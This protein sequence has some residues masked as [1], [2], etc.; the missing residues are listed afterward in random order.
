[1][2][3]NI[4][5]KPKTAKIV[6][7][8]TWGLLCLYAVTLFY[9]YYNQTQ[10]FKTNMFESDLPFHLKFAVEDKYFYSFTTFLY[11]ALSKLP[12]FDWTVALFLTLATIGSVLL[13]EKLIKKICQKNG[14]ILSDAYVKAIA[15]IANVVIAF[16]IPWAG[17]SHYVAYQSGNLWHN[18][19][20]IF[21]RFFA[22]ITLLIFTKYLELYKKGTDLKL[23]FSLSISL[24][25]TT[26]I[27]ASFFTV[28]GPVMAL[29]LLFDLIKGVK[30][31]RVFAAALTVIP[32]C[33]V[34]LYQNLVLFGS[35]TGNGFA[36][37]PFY[38]LSLRG[39]HPKVTFILSIL[40]PLMVGV[41]HVKEVLKNKYYF[42]S[43]LIFFFG[44]I[45]V[46]LFA[47]TGSRG[48][49]GNF[50]WGYSISI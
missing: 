16:Y 28:F 7:I 43:L 37:R 32:S 24:M 40:F 14:I 10:Y 23:W 42:T 20:Y 15:F 19:T 39:E 29:I 8:I 13:T 18:S 22:L 38:T 44:F 6:K 25:I 27:K 35:D 48:K 26:G 31:K 11:L 1:M 34:I 49:D 5:K 30:F 46:F 50:L 41:L 47:E 3:I 17:K 36:I 21:M 2:A 9:L 4:F 12:L 33:A 45:E